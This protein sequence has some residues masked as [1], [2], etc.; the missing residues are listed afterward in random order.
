M[1]I[2]RSLDRP[3]V[4]TVD[5]SMVDAIEVACPV[6]PDSR[7]AVRYIAPNG[8]ETCFIMPSWMARE[9]A[10]QLLEVLEATDGVQGF[11]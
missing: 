1:A 8:I 3:R 2:T 4:E 5:V 7:I 9:H 11:A 6:P 10:Q